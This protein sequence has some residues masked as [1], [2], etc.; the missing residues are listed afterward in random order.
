MEIKERPNRNAINMEEK[1]PETLVE[2]KI[3][4]TVFCS[5]S[6]HKQYM[7]FYMRV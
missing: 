2:Q 1:R 7:E 5:A 4:R 6:S 3:Y